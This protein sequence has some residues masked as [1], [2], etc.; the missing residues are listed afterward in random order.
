MAR[1]QLQHVI[2]EADA[3]RDVV[4]P[5]ALEC[6]RDSDPGLGR[7]PVDHRVPHKTSSMTSMQRRVCWTTPVAMRM[8]PSQPGSLERSRMYTP[9]AAAPATSASVRLPAQTRTKFASLAQY[10]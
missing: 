8:Q 6:Q 2:Q 3:G 4:A 9:R 1:D 7:P 5:L 10:V